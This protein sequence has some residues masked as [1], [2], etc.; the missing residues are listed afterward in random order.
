MEDLIRHLPVIDPPLMDAAGS[1]GFAPD[2]RA[3]ID[4]E[5]FGAFVTNPISARVRR[6]AAQHRWQIYPGGAILHTGHPNPGFDQAVRQFSTR[7]AQSPVPVVVHLLAAS[8][9]VIRDQVMKLETLENILAVEIGF[10]EN[11]SRGEMDEVLSAAFGELPVIARVPLM[12]AVELAAVVEDAGASAISL[13]T[14]RGALPVEYKI[15]AGR[16]YGPGVF[17]LSLQVVRELAGSSLPMIAGGGVFTRRQVEGY[18]NA[19][20]AAVQVDLALWRG[21]WLRAEGA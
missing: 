11:I 12:L 5:E 7:W 6:P 20:A 17:P 1:L 9:E 10:P 16:M 21:D 19:G 3:P 18:I 2:A 14:P 8:P 15:A 4:W 13:C